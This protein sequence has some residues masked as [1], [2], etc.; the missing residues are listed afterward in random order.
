M[1]TELKISL[2]ASTTVRENAQKL[3]LLFKLGDTWS[4]CRRSNELPPLHILNDFLKAGVDDMTVMFG[5][6]ESATIQWSPF[7]LK[8]EEYEDFI[9]WVL[10]IFP[11]ITPDMNSQAATYSEWFCSRAGS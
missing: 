11:D 9:D 1:T 4:I 10:S 6:E 7:V 8:E 2:D 5:S 3:R